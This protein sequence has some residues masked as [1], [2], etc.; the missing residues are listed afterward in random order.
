MFSCLQ[1]INFKVTTKIIAGLSLAAFML[2]D[3]VSAEQVDVEK[4]AISLD[5]IVVT[6]RRTSENL[7]KVPISITA[8]SSAM[9]ERQN[10]LNISEISKSTPSLKISQGR[11]SSSEMFVY[12]RGVGQNDEFITAD[13]GVGIYVD[14]IYMARSQGA[15]LK[16]NDIERIEVL[17]GPQGTLYGKNTVGGAIKVVSKK[18][19][20]DF[21]YDADLTYGSYDQIDGRL[22][23]NIPLSGEKLAVRLS[24]ATINRD[25]FTK[26]DFTGNQLGG[27][28]VLTGKMQLR[29]QSE[30]NVELI[31]SVDGTRDRSTV[32][33]SNVVGVNNAASLVGLVDLAL[34]LDGFG[35]LDSFLVIPDGDVRTVQSDGREGSIM[36]VWG[37]S[38]RASFNLGDV[39]VKS[40]TSYRET[41]QN[42]E[43]DVDNT[44]STILHSLFDLDQSQFSQELQF[45][46]S[47]FKDQLDWLVGLYYFDEKNNGTSHVEIFSTFRGTIFPIEHPLSNISF[48]RDFQTDTKSYAAFFQGIYRINDKLR[49]TVGGRYTHEV[50]DVSLAVLNLFTN[51]ATFDSNGFTNKSFDNF[52]PKLGLDYDVSEEVMLYASMAK[53]FK[54]GGFNGRGGIAGK[55]QPY[56]PEK[57]W[58]YESGIKSRWYDDK[59][60]LNAAG[61]YMSYTDIQLSLLAAFEG[62]QLVQAITNAGKAHIYGLEMELK[63]RPLENLNLFG[64]LGLIEAAYDEYKDATGA[65]FSDREFQ[66]TPKFTFSVGANYM[67]P[68]DG[69]GFLNIGV[70]YARQSKTFLEVTNSPALIQNAYGQLAAR[71]AYESEN[72]KYQLAI[73][74]KN[75]TDS[76]IMTTGA[77]LEDPFGMALGW[78][79]APRTFSMQFKIRN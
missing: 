17:R 58:S 68:L 51:E 19:G 63:A 72:G 40:I 27:A 24:G 12:I 56:N 5:E 64:S 26:N 54:S 60:Q 14:D 42:I 35:P 33:M 66:D 30:E 43:F 49:A 21:E 53:G 11:G 28:S 73:I 59:L 67:V 55:L 45:S 61:F 15:L 47:N 3:S 32:N 39:A 36:D 62:N 37:S 7:Q 48:I 29:F 25:G 4:D 65:D 9:L 52:S 70:D 18:P 38:L 76:T 50:K 69:K 46:G 74:G 78:F 31:F 75:L 16:L 41:K 34:S 23:V 1:N 77:T 13:P 10:I 44:P 22:A 20:S 57:V 8:F 71:I 79:G 2:P 6:A